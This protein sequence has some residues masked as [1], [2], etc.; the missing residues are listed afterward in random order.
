MSATA[1][2]HDAIGRPRVVTQRLDRANLARFS[3]ALG[4]EPDVVP[5]LAHWAF[6][7]DVVP[8][9]VLGADGHPATGGF[10]P[11]AVGLPRRMF[12]ASVV[13]FA[14]P[15]AFDEEA[16]MT[17]AVA[18]VRAKRGGSGELLFVEVDRRIEQRG[19][20]RVAETQT[21]V[22]RGAAAV[23]APPLPIVD[24]ASSEA[25]RPGE[26][27][28]FRFSAATFNAHRIHYDRRYA[29]EE[30]GY[31][32]L[33]VHGPFIAARLAALAARRGALASFEFRA[34]ASCFVGQPIRLAE[35]EA[36]ALD[37]IRC[38]GITAMTAKASYS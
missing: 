5:A 21:L 14:E 28:L 3:A 8:H 1:A 29:V 27:D 38:D 24:L 2:L 11:R 15:L 19:R 22:Y 12:A 36:G 10:V 33:V 25:W 34:A 26:V 16:T 13:R 20:A 35:R 31:P 23:A 18:D 37:A 4:H 9:A 6:F 17:L 30:E 32:D 7:H